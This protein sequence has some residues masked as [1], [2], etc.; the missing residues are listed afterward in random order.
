MAEIPPKGTP[1]YDVWAA[2]IEIALAAPAKKGR[3]SAKAY[4]PWLFVDELRDA[5]ERAG[6]DWRQYHKQVRRT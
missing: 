5:L 2:A 1:E 4:V 6:I 3:G